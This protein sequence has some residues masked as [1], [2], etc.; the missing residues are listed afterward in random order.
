M[1]RR[2]KPVQDQKMKRRR[3]VIV[4]SSSDN[5]QSRTV[6]ERPQGVEMEWTP[7][8]LRGIGHD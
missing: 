6:P 2:V 4:G 8:S 7:P 3:A 1:S 5:G